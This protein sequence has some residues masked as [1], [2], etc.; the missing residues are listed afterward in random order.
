MMR[1]GM[2]KRVGRRHLHLY[3]DGPAVIRKVEA[4][5][6]EE[7]NQAGA[8]ELLM[9]LVQPAELWQETGRWDKRGPNCC[10]SRTATAA[11]SCS[12][13]PPRK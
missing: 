11:I 9:P 5:V 13:R 2:I 10:A 12:S 1:A 7:M 6:R 4:I 8:I 3:A